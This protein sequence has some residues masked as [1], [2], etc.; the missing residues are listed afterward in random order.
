[1]MRPLGFDLQS[2]KLLLFSY[3]YI[4]ILM[5]MTFYYAT[6]TTM[7]Y[8]LFTKYRRMP[9]YINVTLKLSTGDE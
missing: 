7:G 9:R 4:H 8:G 6:L 2:V 1:M 3:S 5:D